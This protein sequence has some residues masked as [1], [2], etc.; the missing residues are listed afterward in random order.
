MTNSLLQSKFESSPIGL[1]ADLENLILKMGDQLAGSFHAKSVA[2]AVLKASDFYIHNPLG[3]TP[4][5][6]SWMQL[7][8]V[9]YFMPLNTLRC[10]MVAAEANRL[11]FFNGLKMS[12][13]FGSGLGAGSLALQTLFKQI[14]FVYK[15]Y[16]TS[17]W[18][19]RFTNLALSNDSKWKELQPVQPQNLKSLQD[20]LIICSYS[21][22]ELEKLPSWMTEA[23]ALMIIE[24]STQQDGRSLMQTR[25]QLIDAGFSIWAP[26][27]HQGTCPLLTQSKTDWCHDRIH[28]QQPAWMQEVETHLPMKNR[29]ITWS[30]LLAKKT[31]PPMA[32]NHGLRTVGD[33]LVQKGKTRQLICRGSDREFLAWMDRHGKAQHI[34]RGVLMKTPTAAQKV[35]DELRMTVALD[36]LDLSK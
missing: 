19:L 34:P 28:L 14:N 21:V 27:T 11:G 3:T 23:Q 6:E 22:T 26:C 31:S 15:C 2:Q 13:D 7:A 36:P 8:Q 17:E 20:T 24:P 10:L 12:Y 4:W 32:L 18:P 1:P 9:Y 30:Y 16:D 29:T 25:Q 35:S 33:P 5:N